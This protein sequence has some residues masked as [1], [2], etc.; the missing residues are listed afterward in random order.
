MDRPI[1]LDYIQ[2]PC[3]GVGLGKMLALANFQTV[4]MWDVATGKPLRQPEAPGYT[5]GA[6]L[7]FSPDGKTLVG[8]A[9]AISGR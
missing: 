9:K 6:V 4:S 2:T 1:V 3:M 8:G 5:P 7:A